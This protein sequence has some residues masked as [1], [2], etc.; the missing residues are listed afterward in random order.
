[1]STTAQAARF[2]QLRRLYGL[3]ELETKPPALHG[4]WKSHF[5]GRIMDKI[6][7][8]LYL[9]CLITTVFKIGICLE[10]LLCKQHFQ[11]CFASYFH[12]AL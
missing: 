1:M 11:E 12:T 7:D 2:R 6:V 9:K 10:T 3:L 4:G 5:V 8:L